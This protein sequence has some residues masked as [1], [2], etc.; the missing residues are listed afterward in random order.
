[1]LQDVEQRI[2]QLQTEAAYGSEQFALV[3]GRQ[4]IQNSGK[5]FVTRVE[6]HYRGLL[7]RAMQTMYTDMRVSIHSISADNL[8]LI[9]DATVNS[10]LEI[11]RLVLRLRDA[12]DEHLRRLNLI[13]GTMHGDYEA[14]ERENPFR[15]YLM[16][17]T[18]HH[19]LGDL[20]AEEET[21]KRLF[22][23]MSE[24]LAGRLPDFYA[25]I[26]DVFETNGMHAELI[27]HKSRQGR[28]QRDADGN[29]IAA[30]GLDLNER[31]LPGLQRMRDRMNQG[32]APAGTVGQAP[33]PAMAANSSFPAFQAGADYSAF[34]S[35][36]GIP[37]I[38][39]AAAGAPVGAGGIPSPQ[40][41]AGA[42]HF[43]F[44]DI[45]AISA[46][47]GALGTTAEGG[48]APQGD[49]GFQN[50]VHGL[51]KLDETQ[52][53]A[54]QPDSQLAGAPSG[55][56]LQ[57]GSDALV[58]RLSQYQQQAALG[59]SI[60]DEISPA[61]NQLFALG[62]QLGP[63][64]VTKLERVA[65]D[66]VAMLFELIL[67]DEQIPEALRE[68]IGRLQIP[69]LKAALLTPDM[70]RQ[71]QHPARQL[72]NRMGSAAVA[73]DLGTPLGLR[74]GQEI[75]RIVNRILEEFGE[76]VSIFS[77][78]LADLERF[79]TENLRSANA[80]TEKGAEALEVVEQKAVQ[81]SKR[82]K[83]RAPTT[84][85]PDWLAEFDIDQRV[86]D[87]IVN[88]WMRVLEQEATA[89]TG[90]TN[91]RV[92][93][94][95]LPDLVWS[96]QEKHTPEERAILVNFLPSLVARLK[97]GLSLLNMT[98]TESR[99]ALDQLVVAH[100]H[101]LRLNSDGGDQTQKNLAEM[102]AHFAQL[103]LGPEIAPTPAIE[104]SQIE[105]ELAKRGVE[106]D[107]DLERVDTP[108]FD[109][110]A[111][112]LA[113]MRVGTCVERWS[114][115]GYQTARLTWVSKRQTLFMFQLEKKT[116]PVVYSAISLIKS[117][118]EGSVRL[119][120]HV[121]VFE[122]AVETLLIGAREVETNGEV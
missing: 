44:P 70:L 24:S 15:P 106:I 10:Q 42:G 49:Q 116:A 101:V 35:I 103:S 5:A 108:T 79:L 55:N 27:S 34:P 45:S 91:P 80:D 4:F 12:D 118:R 104:S 21:R 1:M 58:A 11:D 88:V 57:P 114:D 7:D 33:G 13:I 78:S 28:K 73:L 37:G 43:A 87:F 31:V 74:V 113:Y 94:N 83:K 38:P 115:T 16:A 72:V 8:S 41:S 53:A 47:S 97:N 93:R 105:S 2:V 14:R 85:V 6:N 71:T 77:D 112:W 119:V 81:E 17:C 95:L 110:D 100:T 82:K 39:G 122:R 59:H 18:I 68:Q 90:D 54:S 120:E 20:V 67:N 3:D 117:L 30:A 23:L 102:R 22:S 65:I 98:P 89:A 76:D 86:I 40:G 50:F 62:E 9:D 99:E 109:S 64:Q 48:A 92:Y 26:R 66:V 29:T 111:D 75:T 121:P 19:V 61:Q 51:F 46:G 52:P 25:S 84:V 36:P 32:V 69:F 60:D 107:L 63:D 56:A 96:A